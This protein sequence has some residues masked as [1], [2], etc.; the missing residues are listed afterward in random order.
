MEENPLIGLQYNLETMVSC[1]CFPPT[2]HVTML[3]LTPQC[4]YI[5]CSDQTLKPATGCKGLDFC[6]STSNLIC[7]LR[8]F[9]RRW[10]GMASFDFDQV[11]PR[12][13]RDGLQRRPVLYLNLLILK[14]NS[15]QMFPMFQRYVC[16]YVC[17]Y[18]YIQCSFQRHPRKHTHTQDIT[19]N[20]TQRF[21]RTTIFE[22][23]KSFQG[24]FEMISSTLVAA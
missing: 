5:P 10:Q 12:S 4:Q 11:Y 18:N 21:P 1:T 20:I 9:C 24:I 19:N 6:L 3:N 2:K 7:F 16:M 17:I 22:I 8:H 15:F 23:V 13:G 14:R